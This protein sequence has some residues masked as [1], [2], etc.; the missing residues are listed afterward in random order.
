M[1]AALIIGVSYVRPLS[2]AGGFITD[3]KIGY[4]IGTSPA[5]RRRGSSSA[6][7]SRRNRRRRDDRAERLVRLR[8]RGCSGGTAGK[9]HGRRH[10]APHDRRL[11]TVDTL[12]HGCRAALGAHGHRYPRTAFSLGMFIP[13]YLN[14]PLVVGGLIAWFVANRSKTRLSTR[15]V[16][17]AVRSSPRASSQAV[18]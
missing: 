16:S 5:S 2:M 9:C 15:R 11:D 10:T 6:R 18:H 17:T 13:M 3:L 4:W 8:G 14:A 12:L 1:T 7:P